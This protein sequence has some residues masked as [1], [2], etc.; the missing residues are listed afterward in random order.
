MSFARTGTELIW[1]YM[2]RIGMDKHLWEEKGGRTDRKRQGRQS[3]LG[4]GSA[5]ATDS[6]GIRR[7]ESTAQRVERG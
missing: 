2:H 6:R 7:D 3:P 5:K 4:N 1:L